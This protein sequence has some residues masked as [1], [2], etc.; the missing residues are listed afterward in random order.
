MHYLQEQT[1]VSLFLLPH[2]SPSLIHMPVNVLLVISHSCQI[3]LGSQKS[4]APITSH[5]ILKA[6]YAPFDISKKSNCFLPQY[7]AVGIPAKCLLMLGDIV[8]W[9]EFIFI[10]AK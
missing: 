3:L 2:V 5:S 8:K 9:A 10:S 1:F 7:P 4:C 6:Y